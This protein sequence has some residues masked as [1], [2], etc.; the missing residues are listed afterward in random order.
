[1]Q[2]RAIKKSPLERG[3]RGVCCCEELSHFFFC[4]FIIGYC[5]IKTY[6]RM[7]YTFPEDCFRASESLRSLYPILRSLNP[8]ENGSLAFLTLFV[9]MPCR[10]RLQCLHSLKPIDYRLHPILTVIEPNRTRFVFN[11]SQFVRN[12]TGFV[13]NPSPFAPNG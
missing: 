1:M 6:N 12:R 5:F 3:F 4:R 13:S 9:R 8:M 11:P 2:Y 10:L 7:V